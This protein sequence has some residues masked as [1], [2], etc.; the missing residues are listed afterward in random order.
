MVRL[1]AFSIVWDG[2]L[3]GLNASGHR[4]ARVLAATPF[5]CSAGTP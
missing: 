2:K 3:H 5:P 1:D 4:H